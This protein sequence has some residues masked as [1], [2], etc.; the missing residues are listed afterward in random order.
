MITL[1]ERMLTSS[2]AKLT[3]TASAS[4][5]VAIAW[6]RMVEKGRFTSHYSF[7]GWTASQIILPPMKPSR[8]K[9]IQWSM[10]E[11]KEAKVLPK[12]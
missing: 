11:M 10:E 7:S 5:L 6:V 3:P 8:I 2:R 1:A 12:K 4:M 9:A